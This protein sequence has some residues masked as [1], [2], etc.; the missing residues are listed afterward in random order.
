MFQQL[1]FGLHPEH[2]LFD[3]QKDQHCMKNLALCDEYAE[4]VEQ[5]HSQLIRELREHGE[6]RLD[7][8]DCF[9]NRVYVGNVPHS[10]VNYLNGTWKKQTYQFALQAICF[11][12]IAGLAEA[13]S[14]TSRCVFSWIDNLLK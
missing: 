4:T 7:N 8:P 6:P 1:S 10:W 12:H 14:I 3:I 9:E 11:F 13:S 2:E 5:L